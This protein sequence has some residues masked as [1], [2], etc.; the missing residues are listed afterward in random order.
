V[1]LWGT[2]AGLIGALAFYHVTIVVMVRARGG[3]D[4]RAYA[5]LTFLGGL[6]SPIYLPLTALSVDRLGWR[7]TQAILAAS[8]AALLAAAAFVVP[9]RP[10]GGDHH[11][12]GPRVAVQAMRTALGDPLVR[13]FVVA[14]ALASVVG[15]ALHTFQIPAMVAA[16]ITLAAA[17][18][19]AAIRGLCSLPGRALL[20]VVVKRVSAEGALLGAYLTMTIGSVLLLG[21]GSGFAPAYVVV[22]GIAYGSLLP[23][24]ALVAADLFPAERLGTLMGAQQGLNSLAA[25]TAPV[26]AGVLIDRTGSYAT[27]L[28]VVA[29][30]FALSAALMLRVS[31]GS[32]PPSATPTDLPD[33][34]HAREPRR[35]PPTRPRRPRGWPRMTRRSP[36]GAST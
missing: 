16:G 14:V 2:G 35:A 34:A 23:L 9:N 20:A 27:L 25:A 31:T 8:L 10:G 7:P 19:L 1:R 32:R 3:S 36:E 11:R 21:A 18:S 13:V 24:Q 22:T 26:A 30:G 29:A 12:A 5:A 33:T 6:S 28:L 15:T 4:P 17:S